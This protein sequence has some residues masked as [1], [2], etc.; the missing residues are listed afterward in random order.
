MYA[1]D[2][3]APVPARPAARPELRQPGPGWSH[4]S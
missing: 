1:A 3:P 2:H 4:P